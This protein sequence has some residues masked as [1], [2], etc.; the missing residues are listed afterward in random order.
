M[1]GRVG[2]YFPAKIY[3]RSVKW[4]D[5]EYVSAAV[6]KNFKKWIGL[7]PRIDRERRGHNQENLT[8]D[9]HGWTRMKASRFTK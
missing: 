6:L 9:A 5:F 1:P 7:K 3:F 8:T 2:P 4:G